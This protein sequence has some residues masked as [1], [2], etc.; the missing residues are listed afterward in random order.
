MKVT[1]HMRSPTC[2]TPDVLAGKD[3]TEIDLSPLEADPAAAG[4][5]DRL[6]VKRVREVVEAAIDAR[7][8]HV[9]VGRDLHVQGLVRPLLVVLRDE[10]SKRAC[11]CRTFGAAGFVASFFSVRCI[12]S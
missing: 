5:R 4:H 7:G 6:I 11:C 9:E 10:A 3:V 8:A 12:R 1:S 2:V